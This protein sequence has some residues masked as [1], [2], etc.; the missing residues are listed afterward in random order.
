M[1]TIHF[2]VFVEGILTFISPCI[3]PLL[4]VYFVYLAGSAT[5]KDA[6]YKRKLIINSIGFS[7]G[8]IIVF[9]ALGATATA[10]GSLLNKHMGLLRIISGII[11]VVFGLYFIG[12]I[13]LSF[14]NVQIKINNNKVKGT[15]FFASIVL[16]MVFSLGWSPC[17]G[18]FLASVLLLSASSETLSKGIMLLVIYSAGLSIPF[19][20]SAIL[21]D[22]LRPFLNF[23]SE[24]QRIVKIIS[25]LVLIFMGIILIFNGTSIFVPS[26]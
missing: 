24:K 1:D 4:P 20:L 11:I 2:M 18:P 3:L 17:V 7:L 5:E 26:L 22:N 16:G 25:G 14:L 6:S 19:I 21:I 23:I 8:L 13:K 9:T 12:I 10:F 15:N